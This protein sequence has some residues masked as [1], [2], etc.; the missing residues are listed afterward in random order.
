MY[1]LPLSWLGDLGG[2]APVHTDDWAAQHS[3][4]VEY[5]RYYAGFKLDEKAESPDDPDPPELYPVK[6]NLV[7]LLAH[8]Q[9]DALWGEWE[10][11]VLQLD[12]TPDT[13]DLPS[14]SQRKGA[15]MV[16]RYFDRVLDENNTDK[17][18]WETGLDMMR[19][20]GGLLRVSPAKN[21]RHKIRIQR[22]NVSAFYPVWSPDDPDDLLEAFVAIAMPKRQ[23]ERYYGITSKAEIVWRVE[24]WTKKTYRNIV[25]GKEIPQYSGKNPWG[26]IPL[27][28]FPRQRGDHP[29]YGEAMTED[30]MSAQDELNM[31]VADIG[32]SITYNAHPLKWGYNL[33]RDINDRNKFPFGPSTLW[34]L[35]R[36]LPGGDAP[37]LRLLESSSPIS[38]AAMEHI[39]FV[40]D[41]SRSA[42]YTPPIAFGED[43]GSQRSGATLIIRMWPLT[44]AVRRSR[45]Y[46]K[47]GVIRLL[48]LIMTVSK[49]NFPSEVSRE[50]ARA[51]EESIIVPNFSPILPR[52][53]TD[54]VQ[55]VIQRLSTDP[56]SISL[57]TA[58]DLL[59][60]RHPASEEALIRQEV[61]ERHQRAM[62]QAETQASIAQQQG[63][64]QNQ[65]KDS[66]EDRVA[67]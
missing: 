24:H 11:R 48:D 59:D 19:Y 60:V 20:G 57:S 36:V 1:H 26:V 21:R 32:E 35:G 61:E 22:V 14:E 46:L 2:D 18:F 8:S 56:P 63:Q 25:D 47:A 49:T 67:D 6:M 65:R 12:V 40:Y 50:L 52:E 62:E 3:R 37:D 45:M 16:Q 53:R 13:L 5:Y 58:L 39:R 30:V 23:A 54:I 27:V 41:W 44:R 15:S 10:D 7:R 9:A 51:Y 31:R 38:Q 64:K 66:N 28:Y 34:D 42:S 43:E 17:L 29:F 33:P 55:E 4:Y